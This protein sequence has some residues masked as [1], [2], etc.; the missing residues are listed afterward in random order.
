MDI[1][2]WIVIVLVC[3]L[4][5]FFS[6]GVL[7]FFI[8]TIL[9]APFVPTGSKTVEKMLCSLGDI[10]GKKVYDLGCGD[11]RLV[12]AAEKKGATAVGV[13]ISLPVFLFA[14]LRKFFSASKSEVLLASLWKTDISDADIVLVYLLPKMMKKFREEKFPTLKKGAI[15]VSHGFALPDA[16]VFQEKK[17]DNSGGRVLVYKK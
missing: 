7:G 4:L 14:K 1:V 3:A 17:M 16:D 6:L 13:E 11:G 8:G 10:N 9:G 2:F 12:F 15:L 5:F